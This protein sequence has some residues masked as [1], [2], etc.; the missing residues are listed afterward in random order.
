MTL[1]SRA[2]A[3]ALGGTVV[4]RIVLAPGPGHSRNDRSLSITIDPSA[5]DGFWCHSFAGDDWRVCR[6][7]VRYAL[8]LGAWT[9]RSAMFKAR[10]TYTPRIAQRCLND[11]AL[12]TAWPLKIWRDSRSGAATIVEPYLASRG[13]EP[14]QWPG[15]LRFNPRCLRPRDDDGNFVSPLPAMVALVEHVQHGPIGVHCTY[16]RPD[17]SAK[18]DLPKK[19]QRACF[20][21]IAGGAVRFGEPHPGL[22]LVVGEGIESTLSAALACGLPAWAALSASGIEALLLPSN[23]THVLIAADNDVNGRGQC[24]AHQAAARWLADGRRVRIALPPVG[25]DF[26]DLLTGANR[27]KLDEDR[28]VAA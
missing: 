18:A 5:P 3:G 4:G 26:N 11:T 19:E 14:D 6:N 24:A 16:I 2:V 8:G 21:P 12:R 25:S 9:Q 1:D 15:S 22:W 20:G 23:A 17:G 27:A 10:Q 28:H 7:Y 13:M